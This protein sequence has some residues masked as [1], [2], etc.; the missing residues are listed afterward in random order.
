MSQYGK[1]A[2]TAVNLIKSHKFPE[3]E[4]AWNE[5]VTQFTN[6]E[7]SRKKGCPRYAFLG[8]C[9][10]GWIKD[11]DQNN[12]EKPKSKNADYAIY[13][14]KLLCNDHKLGENKSHWWRQIPN[15]P[16]TQN[17]QLAVVWALWQENMID[18]EKAKTY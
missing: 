7:S 15:A 10:T 16:K 14:V 13:A 2:V 5:A 12:I 18:K 6:S 9:A 11:I 17:G 1:T 8:L 3:A 4:K